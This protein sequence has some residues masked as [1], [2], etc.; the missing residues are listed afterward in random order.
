MK[1]HKDI[2]QGTPEWH[3][4]RKGKLTASHAQEIGNCGK[5]LDTYIMEVLAGEYSSGE[6]EFYKNKDMD[7]GTE[8]EPSARAIY[9]LEN[10]V[11]IEQV[12][13]VEHSDLIGCSPDGLEGEDTGIEVKCHNDVVHFKMILNGADEIESKYLWQIQMNLLITGRKLW[14]YLAYNPNFEKSLLVFDILPDTEKQA[15]LLEGFKIAEAKIKAI[16]AKL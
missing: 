7:R 10:N 4:I 11:V 15:K 8:L 1:I 5:G 16:K 2:I 12:G 6:V 14:R 9:E 3:A 13:F